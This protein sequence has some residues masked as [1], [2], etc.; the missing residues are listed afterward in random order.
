MIC[1]KLKRWEAFLAINIFKL[2]NVHCFF[3]HDAIAHFNRLQ[4][5]IHRTFIG[6]EKPKSSSVSPYCDI[7]LTVVVW[8]QTHNIS[9]VFLY[10]FSEYR[11]QREW[12]NAPNL[13]CKFFLSPIVFTFCQ[14]EGYSSGVPICVC[15]HCV[16]D[17]VC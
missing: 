16:N 3:R 1:C 5:S 15:K 6:T 12:N 17:L 4:G 14:T 2:R 13:S 10:Y 11:N 7:C 8:N 9:K